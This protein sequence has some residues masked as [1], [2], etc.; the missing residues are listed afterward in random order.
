MNVKTKVVFN[1]K[2]VVNLLTHNHIYQDAD[3]FHHIPYVD[4]RFIYESETMKV[5]LSI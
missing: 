5:L 2:E 1:N 3:T 4:G